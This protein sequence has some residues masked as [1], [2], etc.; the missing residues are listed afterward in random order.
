ME[1][2][3]DAAQNSL[4]RSQGMCERDVTSGTYGLAAPGQA[5]L[6]GYNYDYQYCMQMQ[7]T[8]DTASLQ[9]HHLLP[10]PRTWQR[11]PA[12]GGGGEQAARPGCTLAPRG[13]VAPRRGAG[14]PCEV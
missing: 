10:R 11:T 7:S 8:E 2:T 12:A 14:D 9:G 1:T 5:A 13:L 4:L 3:Q 6:A